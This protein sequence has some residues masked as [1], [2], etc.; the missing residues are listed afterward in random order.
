MNNFNQNPDSKVKVE[1]DVTIP[2]EQF[3]LL[4][5]QAN[6]ELIQRVNRQIELLDQKKE[7]IDK[8]N[9]YMRNGGLVNPELMDHQAVRDML[10][11]IRDTLQGNVK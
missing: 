10:T 8:I 11:D 1:C 5:T 9:E 6:L 4:V 7:A 3:D 2:K